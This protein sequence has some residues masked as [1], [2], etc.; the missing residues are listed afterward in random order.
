MLI[1]DELSLL[2]VALAYWSEENLSH[3]LPIN[4]ALEEALEEA[5]V[6]HLETA[7]D[8][9][10]HLFHRRLA[11]VCPD[12]RDNLQWRSQQHALGYA[13]SI[14]KISKPLTSW[15]LS[16]ESCAFRRV[17]TRQ[18][19]SMCHFKALSDLTSPV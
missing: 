3:A 10:E 15:E 14:S 17:L 16:P 2:R 18:Y 13:R 1:R 9:V 12:C 4:E 11:H 7:L 5:R 6:K 8:A 19:V